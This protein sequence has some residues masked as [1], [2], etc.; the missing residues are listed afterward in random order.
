MNK[1]LFPPFNQQNLA[2]ERKK[3]NFIYLS[4]YLIFVVQALIIL[5]SY[6]NLHQ[7]INFVF[8]NINQSVYVVSIVNSPNW[9]RSTNLWNK[10]GKQFVKKYPRNEFKFVSFQSNAN[11]SDKLLLL[12]NVPIRN[13]RSFYYLFNLA[14]ED[15]LKNTKYHWIYRTTEDCLVDIDLFG[16][17]MENITARYS[18]SSYVMRGHAVQFSNNLFFIHGGSGWIMSR[19]A[20]QIYYNSINKLSRKYNSEPT[21][22][23]DVLIGWFAINFLNLTFF[24][25]DD[26]YYLGS[27]YQ[28]FEIQVVKNKTWNKLPNCSIKYKIQKPIKELIF[29]HSGRRDNYPM[30]IGIKAKDVYPPNVYYDQYS[31]P[32]R[33]CLNRRK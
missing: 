16:Q 23:D 14:I 3:Y 25:I 8:F 31:Y 33:L 9:I 17:Y 30:N 10:W 13:Y 29:W 26:P 5:F 24:D 4:I 22:G 18:P 19:P 32:R 15:F 12:K 7:T 11:F 21:S 6:F 27:P 2:N 28:D 20:A 1:G